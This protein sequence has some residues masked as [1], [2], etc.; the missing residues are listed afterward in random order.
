M[1]TS[2]LRKRCNKKVRKTS[3]L[4]KAPKSSKSD[5]PMP[6]FVDTG[7]DNDDQKPKNG[8][9]PGDGKNNATKAGKNLK[10][11]HSQ[12]KHQS[13]L[14]LLTQTRKKK[15]CLRMIKKKNTSFAVGER[16]GPRKILHSRKNWKGWFLWEDPMKVTNYHMLLYM[17]LNTLGQC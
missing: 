1:E 11:P 15:S 4:K 3:Q 8:W 16:R 7:L 5:E 12:K 17:I 2:G 9:R 14:N 6:E 13:H 10:R